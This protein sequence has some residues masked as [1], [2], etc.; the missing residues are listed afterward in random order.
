M[1]AIVVHE[2]VTLCRRRACHHSSRS[3][4][5]LPLQLLRLLPLRHPPTAW[6]VHQP[7][8]VSYPPDTT[9]QRRNSR[10][11]PLFHARSQ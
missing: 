1:Q 7:R 11:N 8:I 5:P 2:Q 6:H 4:V 9:L 10:I 3:R